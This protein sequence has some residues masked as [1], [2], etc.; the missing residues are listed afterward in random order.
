MFAQIPIARHS[1]RSAVLCL[2]PSACC[3]Q[4][5]ARGVTRY[6]VFGAEVGLLLASAPT[7]K[8]AWENAL[9]AL[10]RGAASP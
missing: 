3:R 4:Q 1:A 10:Q 6:V 7:A 5:T 2:I 8:D 9:T